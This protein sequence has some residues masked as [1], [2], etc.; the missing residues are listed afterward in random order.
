MRFSI[1]FRNGFTALAAS[2]V[3][4][5]FSLGVPVA[6]ADGGFATATW[7]DLAGHNYTAAECR[8]HPA[9]VFFFISTQ[10]PISNLYIPRIRQLSSTW[11]RRGV[12]SFVVD[13]NIDDSAAALGKYARQRQ[14]AAPVV[15]DRGTRLA[16]MLHASATPEAVVVDSAGA[17]RYIGRIDDNTDPAQV[18][19]RWLSDAVG[20]LLS[21]TAVRVTRTL[22]LGCAIFHPAAAS[23]AERA[24]LARG[25]AIPTYSGQ[26]AQILDDKCALCH[27]PGESAPFSL[28]D[29][30]E[31]RTWAQQIK[32][33][34]QQDVM[35]PWK[36]TPGWGVF[37]DA[38]GLTDRQKAIL[39]RWADSG[40]PLGSASAV[41]PLPHY[42]SP[43]AW[44][45]GVPSVVLKP[46]APYHLAADG[47]DVYRNFVLPMQFPHDVY[48]S[49][50]AF[51]PQ[52]RAVVHH[53]LLYVDPSG[54]AVQLDG[55]GRQPGYT[56]DGLGIGVYD[57]QWADVW[58]PGSSARMLPP[59]VAIRI[60]KGSVLVMQVHYHKDGRPETDR[61]QV[62]L[63]LSHG[64]VRQVVHV[65][66]LGQFMLHLP[67]G[68]PHEVVNAEQ[69]LPVAV[70]ILSLFPHMHML[71]KSMKVWA[72]L[73][74]GATERL[75]AIADW[76]FN[77]QATYYLQH[78]AALP[79]GTV[80][81][82]QAVFDNT[83][84]N[85][86]QPSHP[87]KLVHFGEQTTDEMDFCF[88]GLTVDGE[89][90]ARSGIAA[91]P[92]AG[93]TAAP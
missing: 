14:I 32:S 13:S 53:I 68:N 12:Q 46:S 63:Y 69:T 82:M 19:Q 8:R 62:A 72:T 26:V 20:D 86:R 70:H 4:A 55:H 54:A 36:P 52:N 75:I 77:W 91:A 33:Y 15:K 61:S 7:R 18:S 90:V 44:T 88:I 40:A 25:G 1:A 58:V 28:T 22:A 35:P 49:G 27:R 71:G 51:Q 80:L 9:T 74:G 3:L 83:A 50:V 66:A 60:P 6:A 38:R 5:A 59:G 48:L 65:D 41:P 29:Y 78:E 31:A 64:P 57:A 24:A 45:L 21:G 81:H 84:N 85:P 76:D 10:C 67:P 56:V 79:A 89:N 43:T 92:G 73:P 87:P 47:K 34:T 37:R 93:A 30:V 16:D 23:A 39:A 11:R 2:T 42:P 17:I